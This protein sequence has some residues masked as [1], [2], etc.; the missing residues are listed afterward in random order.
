MISMT[1]KLL[2]NCFICFLDHSR[3]SIV[4]V[5]IYFNACFGS[6]ATAETYADDISA[7]KLT[8][9]VNLESE[10]VAFAPSYLGLILEQNLPLSDGFKTWSS[11]GPSWGGEY[12]FIYKDRW[13][14]S[15]SGSFKHLYAIDRSEASLFAVSQESTR[16]TRVYHPFYVGVGGRLSYLVPVRKIE[17]PYSRAQTRLIDTGAGLGASMMIITKQG[18][19]I[20]M[21]AHRWRS[22]ST[23]KRQGFELSMS[24]LMSIR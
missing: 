16:I 10:P 22:L 20:A 23:T 14:L 17:I 12:R 19:V 7:A 2:G 11:G 15:V 21:S 13:S 1:L 5:L 24:A 8:P 6:V 9:S 18:F 3:W 4:V